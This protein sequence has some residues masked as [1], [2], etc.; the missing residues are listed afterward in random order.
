MISEAPIVHGSISC[1]VIRAGPWNI[2][3]NGHLI[4][5]SNAN[6]DIGSAEYKVRHLYLS[7]NSIQIGDTVLSESSLKNSARFVSEAPTSS[8]SPGNKCDITQ[9]NNYVYFCFADNN[10][11]RVQKSAW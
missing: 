5:A 1:S 9:D 8:V 11:S 6:F 3:S 2:E 7:N 4:P 10:W